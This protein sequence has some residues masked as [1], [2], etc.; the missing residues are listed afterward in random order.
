M[1][2]SSLKF[3]LWAQSHSVSIYDYRPIKYSNGHFMSKFVWSMALSSF[4][5]TSK[6]QGRMWI[7]GVNASFQ[8]L[9]YGR[10]ER[11]RLWNEWE[12]GKMEIWF[13]GW[14]VLIMFWRHRQRR[15][16]RQRRGVR[17]LKARS[18]KVWKWGDPKPRI[19]SEEK[20]VCRGSRWRGG[21]LLVWFGLVFPLV[22]SFSTNFPWSDLWQIWAYSQQLSNP[23]REGPSSKIPKAGFHWP[24]QVYIPISE[25]S[26]WP[27]Y[28]RLSLVRSGSHSYP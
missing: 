18:P 20:K 3:Q 26:L 16:A 13:L 27:E 11:E 14:E 2:I 4:E 21:C 15:D 17:I 9:D 25:Q 12:S 7:Q 8:K 10:E 24:G 1:W 22:A 6:G 23:S 19:S 5:S 28:K